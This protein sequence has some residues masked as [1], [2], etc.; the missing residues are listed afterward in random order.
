ME[1]V[2]VHDHDLAGFHLPPVIGLDQVQG[3]GFGG[4]DPGAVQLP[5]AQGPEAVRVPGG[6][7]L[8]GGGDHQGI[9]ALDFGQGRGQRVDQID[10]V[11]PAVPGHEVD[12]NLGVHGGLEDGALL[13]QAAADLAGI[14]EGAVVADGDHQTAVLHHEG[15]GVDEHGGAGG[16]IAHV[17]DGQMPRQLIQDGGVEDLGHQPQAPMHADP[18]A[19]AGDDAAGLLA[20]V[21]EGVE[22]EVG[23]A[24]RV[25]VPVNAEDAAVFFGAII[26]ED[27]RPGV[28]GFGF[29]VLGFQPLASRRTGIFI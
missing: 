18:G 27:E 29:W 4:H 8:V 16:G 11:A 14:G 22:A 6:D 12:D 13:L 19:V 25:R 24:G 21:L 28:L 3:A 26:L 15:L 17:A 9:G 10:E 2:L 7:D 1:P 23:D 20:P 5:Q